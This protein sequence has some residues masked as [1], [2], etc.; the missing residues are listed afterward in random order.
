VWHWHASAIKSSLVSAEP[1]NKSR[2]NQKEAEFSQFT[3]MRQE[4]EKVQMEHGKKRRI[5]R[6]TT[7]KNQFSL[8]FR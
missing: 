6:S 7:R 5:T 1:I 8:N 2:A 4:V 3:I